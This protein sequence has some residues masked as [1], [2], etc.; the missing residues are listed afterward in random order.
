[1]LRVSEPFVGVLVSICIAL[2]DIGI[3][4]RLLVLKCNAA[5][6]GVDFGEQTQQLPV[7]PALKQHPPRLQLDRNTAFSFDSNWF[8][9]SWEATVEVD[10]KSRMASVDFRGRCEQ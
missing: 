3:K 9:I 7:H 1:M 4:S 5:E 8:S 6:Q 2:I 10:S